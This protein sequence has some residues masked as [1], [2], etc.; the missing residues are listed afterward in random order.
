MKR[1]EIKWASMIVAGGAGRK[2]ESDTGGAAV[3][4]VVRDIG[5][6]CVNA[7]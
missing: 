1:G 7:G 4:C 6:K 5:E 2:R 3:G